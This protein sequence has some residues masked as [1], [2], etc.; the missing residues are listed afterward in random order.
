MEALRRF[1]IYPLQYTVLTLIHANPGM[2]QSA[3]C[4]AAGIHKTNFVSILN[5]LQRRGLT[6]RRKNTIDRRRS[7]LHLTAR[8]VAFLRRVE[9]AHRPMI[10]QMI[11]R[12][13]K[14]RSQ[15]LISLLREY[16]GNG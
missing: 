14:R 15:Q 2:T 11:A 6:E 5:A 4:E 1:S 10:E 3:I 9:N 16:V 12:L 7:E 8:G 13:G